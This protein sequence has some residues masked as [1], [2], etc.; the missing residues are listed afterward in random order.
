MAE[1][2]LPSTVAP[3][4][5][6]IPASPKRKKT[7]KPGSPRVVIKEIYKEVIK[8]VVREVPKPTR[9]TSVAETRDRCSQIGLPGIWSV[10]SVATQTPRPKETDYK[11]VKSRLFDKLDAASRRD[12]VERPDGEALATP[13]S[14]CYIS[15]TTSKAHFA[16]VSEPRALIQP[17]QTTVHVPDSL[18]VTSTA[19]VLSPGSV[20][21]VGAPQYF[22][23]PHGGKTDA[24][25]PH[26][27][28]STA[29]SKTG[30]FKT[31]L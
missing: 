5:Q 27:E 31:L 25:P 4:D 14:I 7:I 24:T 18:D 20:R 2:V 9:P 12:P 21:F 23:R 6:G 17:T 8:T 3:K 22:P 15:D 1:V 19:P 10:A 28:R 13:G 29:K 30:L 11:N 26:A 16:A